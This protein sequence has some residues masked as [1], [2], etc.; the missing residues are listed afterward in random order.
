MLRGFRASEATPAEVRVALRSWVRRIADPPP[1]PATSQQQALMQEG[2]NN[3]AA[4]HNSTTP[5]QRERA[6]RRLQAYEG[7]VRQLAAAP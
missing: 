3:V 2:C 5:A 7:D 6:A 4:L 1:G